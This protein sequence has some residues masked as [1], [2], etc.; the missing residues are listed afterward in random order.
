MFCMVEVSRLGCVVSLLCVFLICMMLLVWRIEFFSDV[1]FLWGL[2]VVWIVGIMIE[3]MVSVSSM[4]VIGLMILKKGCVGRIVS[5]WV[6]FFL[7]SGLSSRLSIMGLVGICMCLSS[8]LM[9]LKMSIVMMVDRLLDV[10]YV[11]MMQKMRML[12][13]RYGCGM[14]SSFIMFFMC[15]RFS[16]SDRIVVMSMMLMIE[17]MRLGWLVKSVGLGVMFQMIIDL[18]MIVMMELLG[19]LSVIVVVSE[20]L[21]VVLDVV[22]DVVMFLIEFLL[23]ILGCLEILWVCFQLMSL[24]MLLLVV[25][26][27][28]M[29]SLMVLL[30]VVVCLFCFSF[31]WLGYYWLRFEIGWMCDF[32]CVSSWLNSFVMLKR[33]MMM[34]M[35]F[36]FLM[37]FS[38]LNVKCWLVVVVQVLMLLSISLK[39]LVRMFLS[40]DLDEMLI[41]IVMLKMMRVNS[42]GDLKQLWVKLVIGMVVIENSMSEVRILIVEMIVEIVSVSFVFFCLVIGQLFRVVVMDVGVFGVLI[43]MDGIW[44]LKFVVMQ[45]VSSMVRFCMGLRVM[46]KLVVSVMVMVVVMLGKVLIMKLSMRFMSMYSR[47]EMLRSEFSFFRSV[48]IG[49]F[50]GVC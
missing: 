5:V 7:V 14:L 18:I 4:S 34:V 48:F 25:G 37:S 21:S 10:V 33:L 47:I 23:N 3:S 11:L 15:I 42:L 13:Y 28:L 45:I 49:G 17:M 1:C 31:V 36:M 35:K 43:R 8:M 26:M 19:M 46:V 40:I 38:M 12:F 27:S 44:F 22:F 41:M 29:L 20:L 6:R 2:W 50:L 16:V 9:M 24:V 39:R 32:W 30:I